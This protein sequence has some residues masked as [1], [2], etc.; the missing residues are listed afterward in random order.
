MISSDSVRYIHTQAQAQA[1][2][3]RQKAIRKAQYAIKKQRMQEDINYAQKARIDDARRANHSR[4]DKRKRIEDDPLHVD[5]GKDAK[6]KAASRILA[7]AN[8]ETQDN[9]DREDMANKVRERYA[10]YFFSLLMFRINELDTQFAGLEVTEHEWPTPLPDVKPIYKT[11]VNRTQELAHNFVCA[12]CGCISHDIAELETVPHSFP[13]LLRHLRVAEDVD[14]RFDFSCGID[15]LDR[16]RIFI[17]KLAITGSDQRLYLCRSCHSRLSKDQQ[18][19]ESLANFRFVRPTVPE[20]LQGLTWIEELLIARVHVNGRICRLGERHNASSSFGIK[21]HVVFLPQDTS[22]LLDLLPMSPA[23]LPEVVKVVWTGKS[24]P[25]KSR[26]RSRFTVRKQKVYNA[27]QWLVRNHADYQGN[28]TIDE[29]LMRSWAETFVV[30]D[31]LDTI[32]RV[33]DPSAEDASRDGF[34][35]DNPDEDG[36]ADDDFPLTSSGILDVNNVAEVPDATTLAR[37][38]Q[39]KSDIVINV[40]T[41]S[42]VLNQYDCDSY[43]TSAFVGIFID[44]EAKHRDPRRGNSQLSLLSWVQLMLRNSSR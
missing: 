32:G 9:L 27:L 41:G 17:D 5:T 13:P 30:V 35:M 24:N 29:E 18:P 43:F 20:E 26:L 38:A 7:R 23:S 25:D 2:L 33:S 6:R 36:T 16:N 28:V 4:A 19:R 3:D 34:A 8:R 42:K 10:S 14:V 37:L 39:L 1:E 15:L 31:L 22:R 12:S 44:G 11:F 21:G 40:V